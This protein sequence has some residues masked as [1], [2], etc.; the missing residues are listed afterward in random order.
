MAAHI[1]YACGDCAALPLFSWWS[2]LCSCCPHMHVCLRTLCV[3]AS[4]TRNNMHTV[5]TSYV[6]FTT[7]HCMSRDHQ[8]INQSIQFIINQF[9]IFI[10][11]NQS[12]NQFTTLHCMSRAPSTV[13]RLRQDA[14]D[15]EG[16]VHELELHTTISPAFLEELQ[17]LWR[18]VRAVWSG[19]RLL[20]PL[21]R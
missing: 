9:T 7:R 18:N 3:V 10:V 6:H 5:S 4:T 19:C 15:V 17:R 11:I 21:K 2:G 14:Q 20:V 16:L 8:F 13:W 12:I 1:I